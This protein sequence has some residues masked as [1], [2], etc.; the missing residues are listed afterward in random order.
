MS[1]E[2]KL[3]LHGGWMI[4]VHVRDEW[5]L[6]SYKDGKI[7]DIDANHFKTI[8]EFKAWGQEILDGR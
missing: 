8:R 3:E 2:F 6:W 5:S 7:D 4:Y 1:N